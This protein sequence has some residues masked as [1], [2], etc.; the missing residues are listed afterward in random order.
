[1]YKIVFSKLCIIKTLLKYLAFLLF[2]DFIRL[3]K[4]KNK[5]PKWQVV[6]DLSKLFLEGRRNITFFYAQPDYK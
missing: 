6:Y 3:M 4:V 5:N 1:M 2:K